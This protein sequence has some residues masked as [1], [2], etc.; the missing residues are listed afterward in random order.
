MEIIF[1]DKRLLTLDAPISKGSPYAAGYDLRACID[2]CVTIMPG[3]AKLIDTGIRLNMLSDENLPKNAGL[4]ALLFP[5]SGLGH[6][7]GL[8][9]GNGTGVIDMDYQGEIKVSL[10]NRGQDIQRI[11]PLDRIAQLVF[12]PVY[13]PTFNIVR[14]FSDVTDRGEGGFG[15][16][17]KQ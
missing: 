15:S 16:T 4:V 5:R 11:D 17:G 8:V 10:L 1:S 9:L 13:H 3:E 12:M 14:E 6:K 7:R 2:E